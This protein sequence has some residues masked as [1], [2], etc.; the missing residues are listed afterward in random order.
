VQKSETDWQT[1][2]TVVTFKPRAQVDPLKLDKAMDA[3]GFGIAELKLVARGTPAEEGGGPA[4]KVS[5]SEQ[6]FLVAAGQEQLQGVAGKEV[7]V[8]A[9]VDLQ[10]G[11]PPFTLAIEKVEP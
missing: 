6:L 5:G 4:F 2:I 10:A 9:K 1:A 11:G 8:T 7:T 3:A